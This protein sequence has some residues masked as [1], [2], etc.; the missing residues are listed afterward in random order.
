MQ[1]SRTYKIYSEV[2]WA[3]RNNYCPVD[4]NILLTGELA[5]FQ[6]ARRIAYTDQKI[7]DKEVEEWLDLKIIKYFRVCFMCCDYRKLNEK[8]VRENFPMVQMDSVT[9][10]LHGATIF[11]LLDLTN[12]YFHYPVELSS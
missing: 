11:T 10:K 2:L 6:Y 8:I 4:M 5:E 7:L 9:E 12:G 3:K 1:S